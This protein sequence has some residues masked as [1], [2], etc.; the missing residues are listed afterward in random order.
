TL[1]DGAGEFTIYKVGDLKTHINATLQ[2]NKPEEGNRTLG[3]FNINYPDFTVIP[4]TIYVGE[5]NLISITA[6]DYENKP[7]E[8]IYLT[9]V[10]SVPGI[11]AARPDPVKTDEDGYVELSLNP[12]ASGK[13]NVT[14]ARD[15][16]Y[17]DGKLNWT[18]AVIT[19]TYIT[20]TIR[21]TMTLNHP[22]TVEEAEEFTVEALYKGVRITDAAVIIT[23][24]GETYQTTNG[25]IEITAPTVTDTYDWKI[26]ANAEG[27]TQDVTSW[28][29]VINKPNLYIS[30]AEKTWKSGTKYVVKPY[31]DDGTYGITVT[32]K[33][34]SGNVVDT[35]TAGPDGATFTAPNV[36]QKTTYTISATKTGYVPAEEVTITVESAGI[37][38]FELLTLVAA[39]GVAFILLRRRRK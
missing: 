26:I 14:I 17:E 25:V 20:A 16:K 8:G 1:T 19:D 12:L 23:F 5:S 13:L 22:P 29:K 6:K 31:A 36:K 24:A 4:A 27:Y 18:D 39:I 9:V 33:D 38:G 10:S 35:Q 7:I 34:A 11:L 28:I 32:L 3:T 2:N 37:P 15:V 30:I 21:K